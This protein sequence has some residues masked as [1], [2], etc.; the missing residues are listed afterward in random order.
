MKRCA[1]AGVRSAVG[2]SIWLGGVGNFCQR[3]S[4]RIR[5]PTDAGAELVGGV[6]ARAA[7]RHLHEH[8][9]DRREDHHRDGADHPGPVVVVAVAAEE[10]PELRQHRDRAGDGGGDRHR[11]RVVV[12][13]MRE[14][15][16]EHAGDL[17]AREH[18][19]QPGR[20]RDR[21][22]LGIA[23]GSERIGL[24]IVHDVDARHRQAGV[25]RQ[26]AH[27]AHEIGRGPLVHL[28]GIVH[29]ED[30]LVR[31]PIA[32]EVHG[33]GDEQRDDGAALAADEI[34][35]P[36][37]Q[38]G[39]PGQQDGSTHVVHGRVLRGPDAVMI[40]DILDCCRPA[41]RCRRP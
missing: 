38:G 7:D 39:Q 21:G 23:A 20:H 25:L 9:G 5:A 31:V 19:Q 17:L 3:R 36:H 30:E 15:V 29:G 2:F 34:A 11:Q 10:H 12:S 33:A 8:G 32:G 37:E 16:G 14:L 13:D 4:Q 41:A 6:F 27:Q 18:L 22:V 26:L 40:P 28:L 1:V 24:R 35:D